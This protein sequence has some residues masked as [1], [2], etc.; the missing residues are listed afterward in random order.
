MHLSIGLKAPFHRFASGFSSSLS[1]LVSRVRKFRVNVLSRSLEILIHPK[2]VRDASAI[3]ASDFNLGVVTRN[4]KKIKR[5][6]QAGSL[7]SVPRDVSPSVYAIY[8]VHFA[9]AACIMRYEWQLFNLT[10]EKRNSRR[11]LIEES[12]YDEGRSIGEEAS[13]KR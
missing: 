7:M 11:Y 12:R 13:D 4:N 5:T 8:K 6:A 9:H 3:L 2:S 1:I 10:E